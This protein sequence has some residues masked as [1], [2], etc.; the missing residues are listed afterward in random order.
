MRRLIPLFDRVLVEKI[1]QETVTKSGIVL[2]ESAKSNK[3]NEGKVIAVGPGRRTS[4]GT[5]LK[6][7]VKEGDFVLLGESYS[8]Q[9]IKHEDKDYFIYREEDILAILDKK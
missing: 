4:D 8:G 1:K 9:S 5:L 3:L 2:P 6:P 7:T